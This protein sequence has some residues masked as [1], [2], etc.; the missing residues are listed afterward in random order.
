MKLSYLI[1]L[2]YL[3][4]QLSFLIFVQ[5]ELQRQFPILP[6]QQPFKSQFV[7]E[8]FGQFSEAA[9]ATAASKVQVSVAV[10]SKAS[11][12]AQFP[13]QASHHKV[14]ELRRVL[15]FIISPLL[16]FV[17]PFL[18]SFI[19]VET[20][21]DDGRALVAP[22]WRVDYEFNYIIEE[23]VMEGGTFSV[24]RLLISVL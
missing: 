21:L 10:D 9:A 15:F 6:F 11:R 16:I 1:K 23:N 8:L 12:I 18:C 5:V 24:T 2:S 14:G 3:P 7:G 20:R 22:E 13:G 4:F 19:F 17:S